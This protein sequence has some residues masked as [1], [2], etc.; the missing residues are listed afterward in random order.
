MDNPMKCLL[1]GMSEDDPTQ[2]GTDHVR[3]A[4]LW[5]GVFR[6]GYYRPQWVSEDEKRR[7][8]ATVGRSGEVPICNNREKCRARQDARKGAEA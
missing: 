3:V 1:C 6:V 2:C 8:R 5:E 7:L 4:Y